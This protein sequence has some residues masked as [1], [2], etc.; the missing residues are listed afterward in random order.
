MIHATRGAT[1]SDAEK[2]SSI[3]SLRKTHGTDS[4]TEREAEAEFGVT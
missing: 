3:S 4:A 2:A 1:A